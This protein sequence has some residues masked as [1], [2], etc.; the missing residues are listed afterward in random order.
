MKEAQAEDFLNET[1]LACEEDIAVHFRLLL[2]AEI[3][4]NLP[5]SLQALK[6]SDVI[7]MV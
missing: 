7:A 6:K 1:D 2:Q 3:Q 5:V 4:I